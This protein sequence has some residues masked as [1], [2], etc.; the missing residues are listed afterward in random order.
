MSKEILH[1]SANGETKTSEEAINKGKGLLSQL[2]RR[3][4]SMP[5]DDFAYTDDGALEVEFDV[6]EGDEISV[7]GQNRDLSKWFIDRFEDSV[8]IYSSRLKIKFK[9]YME[10]TAEGQELGMKILVMPLDH[11]YV[12]GGGI[13]SGGEVSTPFNGAP[14]YWRENEI[15]EAHSVFI[16]ANRLL[17]EGRL[18][19]SQR[20]TRVPAL[21]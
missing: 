4:A 7:A 10:K 1:R 8:P 16:L 3:F 9:P 13:L 5:S 21:S 6:R 17:K 18:N 14:T 2:R 19:F 15:K 11:N 12:N 20:E